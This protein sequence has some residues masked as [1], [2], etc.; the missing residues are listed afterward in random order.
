MDKPLIIFHKDCADGFTSAWIADKCL[1]TMGI[2]P[3]LYGGMYGKDVPDVTDRDVYL[4][5]FTYS[6]DVILEMAKLAK[7]ITILDHH[8]TAMNQ[9]IDHQGGGT[10]FE[11]NMVNE[12]KPES[13]SINQKIGKCILSVRFNMKNSGAMMTWKHFSK[14][15]KHDTLGNDNDAPMLVQYVQDRDLWNWHLPNSRE[16]SSYIFSFEY[17]LENWTRLEAELK[18]PELRL[19]AT[20]AG[21]GIDRKHFKDIKEF[22]AIATTKMTIGGFEVDVTNVPYHWSS[23]AA[24]ILGEGKPFGAS[25]YER[26]DG[27]RVFSLRSDEK[28]ENVG[29]IAKKYGGGGHAHASGF[30]VPRGWNGEEDP[31]AWI[32]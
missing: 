13:L 22:L 3:E 5:D 31:H 1:K 2:T 24:H 32:D 12:T 6:K 19:L 17:T 20:Q 16:I 25:Y 15:A 28:G 18:S 9:W 30:Q 11:I 21:E 4:V 26:G 27:F 14:L 23:D 7:S 8:E 10:Y 29:V